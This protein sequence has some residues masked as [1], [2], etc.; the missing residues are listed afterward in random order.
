MTVEATITINRP[1]AEVFDFVTDVTNMPQWVTGVSSAELRTPEMGSGAR[2]VC[3]YT[4]AL[5]PNEIEIE[6]STYDRPGR[7]G[8]HS[9][10]GPFDFEGT[11][12][13]VEVDG[14]TVVTNSIVADPDSVATRIAAILF[15][16]FVGPSMRKRLTRELETLR[17]S[18]QRQKLADA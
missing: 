3:R 10:R 1:S 11:M 9:A 13:L 6:V 7:F 17:D 16:W 15:G 2:F 14:G 8:L 5:R 18:I 12:T 4:S